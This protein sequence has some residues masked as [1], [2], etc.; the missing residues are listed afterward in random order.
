VA[1]II[2]ERIFELYQ[3]EVPYSAEVGIEEFRE[4]PGA[5]DYIEATIYV[6][7]E[8]QKAIL[9]G[10]KGAAIRRLGEEA[11]EEV[12]AFLGRPVYLA[13]RVRILPRWRRRAEALRRLGYRK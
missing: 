5:K 7:Q 2:R 9:I 1:E 3:E 10:Q 4:R 13:L 11:R 6:E 8:S 12:E